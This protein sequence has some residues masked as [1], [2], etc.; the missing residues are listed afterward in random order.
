MRK[1]T[2]KTNNGKNAM[3]ICKTAL[4]MAVVLIAI[5]SS[6]KKEPYELPPVHIGGQSESYRIPIQ[7]S[8]SP[9]EGGAVSGNKV[10]YLPNDTCTITAKANPGYTFVNWTTWEGTEVSAEASYNFIVKEQVHYYANFVLESSEL[11]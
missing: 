4:M 2:L 3:H 7:A 10:F 8:P 6:C 9:R 1:S 11:K 5:C